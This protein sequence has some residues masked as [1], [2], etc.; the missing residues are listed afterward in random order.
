MHPPM[1]LLFFDDIQLIEKENLV[2]HLGRPEFV[3]EAVIQD[4][5]VDTSFS[6]PTVFPKVNTGG[7]R[8]LYQGLLPAD[9]NTSG[10]PM[11]VPGKSN[12]VA[13]ILDS[14]DG[15]NWE[16]PDLT[17]IVSIDNRK[18]PHQVVPAPSDLFGEWGPCYYDDRAPRSQRIKGFVCKG[19]GPGTGIKDSWIVT[20]EDGLNWCGEMHGDRW[21]P[22][23]SDP[24]VFAFWNFRRNSYVLIIRPNNGDR[25]I[26][27]METP[28][29]NH[30]SKPELALSSDALDPD[31]AEIYGMPTFAYNRMFIGLVWLYRVPSSIGQ[32]GKFV[33]G[34]I[35]CQLAYSYDGWHFNRSIRDSFIS[36]DMSDDFGSG[37]IMPSSMVVTEKEIRF[38]SCSTVTEHGI[39]SEET[40]IRQS[41]ILMHKMRIDGFVYLESL[42]EEGYFK[43]KAMLVEGDSLS[44]NTDVCDGNVTVEI[45]NPAGEHIDGY[46]FED[47]VPSY[48]DS[49]EW[50]PEWRD[51]KKFGD[52]KGFAVELGVKLRNGK[53]YS[54]SGDF[55]M[56]TAK[57]AMRYVNFGTLPDPKNW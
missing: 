27:V 56:L 48:V 3:P 45:S 34:T 18:L 55:E 54:I 7:W 37:C 28:D 8:C 21:H 50:E 6:Y 23:G 26:A 12:F 22:Y 11:I 38:Y 39:F 14:E 52:L 9:T 19:H 10:V 29:W 57:E 25:R 32:Y 2:R 40:G 16:V 43:T 42:G 15:I 41:A 31:L 30:F 24:A 47:C 20:S 53:I 36:N 13:C 35:D 49:I 33:G 51:G 1:K 44:L 4:S 5:F 46:G 17:K